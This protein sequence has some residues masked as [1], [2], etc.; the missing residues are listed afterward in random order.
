MRSFLPTHMRRPALN[1]TTGN[2][3]S[4]LWDLFVDEANSTIG[5]PGRSKL[6]Q[7]FLR[8]GIEYFRVGL[9]VRMKGEING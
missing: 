3:K 9:S 4:L 8:S 2:P 1:H 5:Y 6:S 7:N